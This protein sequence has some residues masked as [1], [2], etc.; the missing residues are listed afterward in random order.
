M[1]KRK[2]IKTQRA[3]KQRN[4]K[5]ILIGIIAAA[6][7]LVGILILPNLLPAPSIERPKAQGMAFGD[8]N[9]PV[10]I[11]QFSD[12]QCSH[13]ADYAL[14]MEPEIIKAFVTSG[15][16]YMKFVPMAFLGDGSAL[17]A[18]AAYC[19]NDQNK[20]WDYHDVLFKNQ[21][22]FNST[23]LLSLASTAKLDTKAFRECLDSG[24]YKQKVQDD[25]TYAGTKKVEGTPSFLVNNQ[26]VYR[27]TL[28]LTIE[29]ALANLPK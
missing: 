13:C 10:K 1:S 5:W 9:A 14:N 7:I 28:K 15:K 3:N 23:N 21:A 6:V 4:E 18:E 20:F 26:L 24:K 25:K 19:A 27:D 2:V 8:P 22:N 16:V 11:E 12:F 17:S 29:L